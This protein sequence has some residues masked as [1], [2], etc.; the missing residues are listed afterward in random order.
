M[1]SSYYIVVKHR[2][3]IETWN[4]TPLTFGSGSISY[5]FSSLASQALG[6]N[7][8]LVSGKFVIYSGDV[9]QDGILDS[10]DMT[11][12]DIDASNF[13]NGYITSDINGDG[14]IDS[15]DMILLDNNATLFIAKIVP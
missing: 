10:S 7:Q 14:I 1:G 9:N 11:S 4:S 2:N 6:S 8:K 12:M 3:S 15:S 5:N 13:A